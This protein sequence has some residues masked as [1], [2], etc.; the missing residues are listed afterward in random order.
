MDITYAKT[1][2][3]MGKSYLKRKTLR[4]GLEINGIVSLTDGVGG[5]ECVSSISK[6]FEVFSIILIVF[7]PQFSQKNIFSSQMSSFS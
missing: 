4:R 5:V 3:R 2:K 1:N 6:E 7:F